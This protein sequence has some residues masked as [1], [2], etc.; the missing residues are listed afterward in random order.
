MDIFYIKRGVVALLI[1]C[2]FSLQGQENFTGFMQTSANLDYKVKPLYVHN[3]GIELRN[4]Y[5]NNDQTNFEIQQIDL[6]HFSELK[7]LDNQSIALGVQYR[8]RK[9]CKN[10]SDDELRITEQ[11]NLTKRGYN[12]RHGHRFRWE[13]RIKSKDVTHRFRYRYAIDIPLK[14]TQ[15]DYRELYIALATES[16]LTTATQIKPEFDQ[17]LYIDFGWIRSKYINFEIGL[18]YRAEDLYNKIGNVLILNSS[19]N[20]SL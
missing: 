8:F 20:F 2:F 13:Q 12:F 5:Y 15:L 14:G 3:N 17:R 7:L 11:Y 1:G 9:L 18:E 4:Y 10:S 19:V 16:L 6:S